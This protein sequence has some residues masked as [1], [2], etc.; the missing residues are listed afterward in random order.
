[1][2]SALFDTGPSLTTESSCSS[3]VFAL[4]SC[5]LRNEAWYQCVPQDYRNS[6]GN[7]TLKAEPRTPEL[8]ASVTA[9]SFLFVNVCAYVYS[10][11]MHVEAKGP[12]Q[13]SSSMLQHIIFS[14][15]SLRQ[16]GA[17]SPDSTR[18]PASPR[19]PPVSS[20][21]ALRLHL[22]S[23]PRTPGKFPPLLLW[24]TALAG[25]IHTGIT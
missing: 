23:P 8:Q 7:T 19:G 14:H 5:F 12:H 10:H 25:T 16:P 4:L 20:S 21:L 11:V 15:R 6:V 17:P 3:Q 24:L 13:Q 1:M 22:P 2:A 9:H 18:W